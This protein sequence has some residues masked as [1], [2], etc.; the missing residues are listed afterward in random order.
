MGFGEGCEKLGVDVS[1]SLEEWGM[2]W[3]L[4]TEL[5][6]KLPGVGFSFSEIG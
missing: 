1:I 4:L 6:E 5:K 2:W 3:F